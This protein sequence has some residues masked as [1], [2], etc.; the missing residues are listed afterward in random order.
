[1]SL[2]FTDECGLLGDVPP[3]LP[4]ALDDKRRSSGVASHEIR[5]RLAGAPSWSQGYVHR[6]SLA[7]GL[8]AITSAYRSSVRQGIRVAEREGVTVRTA[9]DP[10]DLVETFYRLHVRTRRRLGVPV[11]RR[12]YFQLLWERADRT[13]QRLRAR[14]RTTIDSC[15]RSRVLAEREHGPL[16]VRSVGRPSLEPSGEQCTVPIGDH[17]RRRC[18]AD[19][20]DW[21][22]TDFADD[23]LRRFKANWGSDEEELTYSQLGAVAQPT[24]RSSGRGVARTIIRRSP[25]AVS[26][27]AGALLYRYAA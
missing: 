27:L 20:F 21:G 10:A 13:R 25:A 5:G 15:C 12:R 17:A 24:T 16:Q 14:R 11:Q 1:M 3:W 8:D 4:D 18:G 26:R 19:H 7:P 22:R 6:L 2:P 23:G 9:G